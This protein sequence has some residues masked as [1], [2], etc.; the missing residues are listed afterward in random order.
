[1]RK[2]DIKECHSR[3]LEMAKTVSEIGEK[4]GV[5][6][7]ML[8]GTMLGAIRH[9]GFIPWD[10]DMDFAVMYEQYWEFA[11]ILDK[12]LPAQ[13]RCCTY[14]NHPG[15]GTMFYQIEDRGTIAEDPM[16]P[17]PEDGKMGIS[18]DIFPMVKCTEEVFTNQIPKI[19]RWGKVARWLFSKTLR[20]TW[21]GKLAYPFLANKYLLRLLPF[22][23]ADIIDKQMQI[24]D[25]I[26]PGELVANPMSPHF[27]MVPLRIEYFFPLT[28]YPFEDTE[29]YG[30]NLYDQY[31]T[32]LYGD[33][34]RIPPK[35]KQR[36]HLD[37][38]YIK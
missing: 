8:G 38:V 28:K 25:S 37:N 36:V 35:S 17:L 31:L 3:L 11:E 9:K 4:H 18:I 21:Q 26:K 34:M 22:T 7:Y 14:K 12:E 10:D 6:V 1:M 24:M 15:V 19:Q 33:Y 27:R 2:M 29:F 13:Y 20:R 23:R 5:P 32:A 30:V 16:H